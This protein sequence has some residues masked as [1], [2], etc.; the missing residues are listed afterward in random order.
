MLAIEICEM[1]SGACAGAPIRRITNADPLPARLRAVTAEQLYRAEWDT[2]L[3]DLDPKRDYRL[4]VLAGTQE[5]GHADLLVL[6]RARVDDIAVSLMR[7]V[8]LGSTL[9]IVFRVDSGIA[10]RVGPAGAKVTL[11]GGDV[12]FDVP[13]GALSG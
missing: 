10:A 3:N 5:F 1:R 2:R 11:A 6:R 12:S 4:R 9:S 7:P 8:V 13:A